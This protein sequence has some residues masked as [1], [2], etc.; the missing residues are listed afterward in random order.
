MIM[1][2][3]PRR[4]RRRT[5]SELRE[6]FYA[7]LQTNQELWHMVWGNLRKG[8]IGYEKADACWNHISGIRSNRY[9]SVYVN[10]EKYGRRQYPASRVAY[11]LFRKGMTQDLHVCHH[12]DNPA[13]VNP[14]HLFLGTPKDN[15]EDCRNKGRH[16]HGQVH[17]ST[18]LTEEDVMDIRELSKHGAL[19]DDLALEYSITQPN[20]S[21][22]VN[23]HSWSHI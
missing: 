10:T 5:R 22:I 13:C 6:E 4:E 17:Y 23:R 11:A 12:C 1:R 7:E 9:S 19:Q 21:M 15:M 18:H 8:I 14:R 16:A 3:H 2:R 20:I